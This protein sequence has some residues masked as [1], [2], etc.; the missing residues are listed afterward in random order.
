MS[1]LALVVMTSSTSRCTNCRVGL[2]RYIL[3]L[4]PIISKCKYKIYFLLV[5]TTFVFCERRTSHFHSV[6]IF[7]YMDSMPFGDF[8]RSR[9]SNSKISS[10]AFRFLHASPPDLLGRTNI[11]VTTFLPRVLGRKSRPRLPPL[12]YGP[13]RTSQ[14]K[15]TFK[16][17]G[18]FLLL[19]CAP[20]RNRTYDRSLKRRLLYQLSYERIFKINKEN[21]IIFTQK[22]K[23][24][25][26]N[27]NNRQKQW[28]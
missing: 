13:A 11:V 8:I 2:S 5:V 17:R 18:V 9:S 25:K 14:K 26:R 4:F 15:N 24:F 27:I 12:R 16:I 22:N 23:E 3:I 1:T 19:R 6:G 20:S 7:H 28:K 10:K 21:F